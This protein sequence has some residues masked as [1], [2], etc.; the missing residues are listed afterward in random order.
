MSKK[1]RLEHR[2]KTEQAQK[3]VLT[4]ALQQAVTL[5]QLSTADLAQYLQ[6]QLLNNP[7]LEIWESAETEGEPAGFP[8]APESSREMEYWAEFAE[9]DL[10]PR[11]EEQQQVLSVEDC[12]GEGRDL[13]E[14][15]LE[16]LRFLDLAPVEY[17]M[18]AFL[19]GNLDDHGYLRY[20]LAELAPAAGVT[21][22]E[23][24]AALELVQGL[25]PPGI[26]CR[27]LQECLLLQLRRREGVPP[28]ALEI[29][30]RHLDDLVRERYRSIAAATGATL[31]QVRQ[32]VEVIRSLNPRPGSLLG[33]GSV[34]R[35]L[36]PDLIVKKVDSDYQ[37]LTNDAAVPL[38][39][40]NPL[41]RELL[42]GEA[43]QDEQLKAFL[44]E[45][46][47]SALWLIRCLEQR[48][49]TLFRIA[50]EIVRIQRPFLEKG[51]KELVPLTLKDVARR[52]KVHEST[53][54]RAVANKY[55]Q[56]P[57]GLYHMKFFFSRG[58]GE[59]GGKSYSAHS[60]KLC[61]QELIKQE[62]PQ[63]PYSDAQLA[64][65]LQARGMPLSRRTVAKYRQEQ[66][67][68]SSSQRRGGWT[69]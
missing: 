39:T 41:Y 44:R 20:P 26:G 14:E 49:L 65:M 13:H 69:P 55:I 67:I 21:E 56:T 18:A 57:R 6:E 11:G 1:V 68:P 33:G 3:M 16:Q 43:Q 35:Y 59:P 10:P 48:R 38:L 62:D 63:K 37:V 40:I 28:L 42:R 12:P 29:V 7:V 2:L 46:M 52:V 9:E 61:L 5:L 15:L 22:K 8:E 58:Y 50:Q 51:L 32:A 45:K 66:N 53:V 31:E 4:P 24:E 19:I 17:H 27:S 47:E 54:S 30:S 25:D 60:V 36:V 34:T 64:R 23:L